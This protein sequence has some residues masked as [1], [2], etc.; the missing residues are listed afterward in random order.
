MKPKTE[1]KIYLGYTFKNN[2]QE[3]DIQRFLESHGLKDFKYRKPKMGHQVVDSPI[4][5]M[6]TRCVDDVTEGYEVGRFFFGPCRSG[7]NFRQ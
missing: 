1:I 5:T 6:D 7:R 2:E 3:E 4:I